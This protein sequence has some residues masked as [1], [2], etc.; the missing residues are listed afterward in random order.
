M[1]L[2]KTSALTLVQIAGRRQRTA[3]GRGAGLDDILQ[4]RRAGPDV[5]DRVESRAIPLAAGVIRGAIVK[6]Q[7]IG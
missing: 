7:R 1:S 6:N 2:V 4:S 3:T 5:I